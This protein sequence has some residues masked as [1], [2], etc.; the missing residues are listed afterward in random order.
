MLGASVGTSLCTKMVEETANILLLFISS[1]GTHL[2]AAVGTWDG[3]V[4]GVSEG[5]TDLDGNAEGVSDE[6][7]GSEEGA[8]EQ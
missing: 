2:G 7:V 8:S 4:V 6:I 5:T 1:S 3:D